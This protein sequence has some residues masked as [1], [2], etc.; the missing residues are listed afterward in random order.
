ML[1]QEKMGSKIVTSALNRARYRY[2]DHNTLA[3]CVDNSHRIFLLLFST[4]SFSLNE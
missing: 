3:Q 2:G 1:F 4:F